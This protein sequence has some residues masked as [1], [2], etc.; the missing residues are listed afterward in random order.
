MVEMMRE[1]GFV[2]VEWTPY[3]FGIAGLWRGERVS[4]QVR[5]R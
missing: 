5:E 4:V 1:A 3:T 2:E